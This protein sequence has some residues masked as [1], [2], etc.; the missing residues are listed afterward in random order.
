[1]S[2]KPKWLYLETFLLRIEKEFKAKGYKRLGEGAFR[3]VCRKPNGKTV[4]KIPTNDSGFSCNYVEDIMYRKHKSM[5]IL[6]KCN[7]FHYKSI[8]IIEMEYVVPWYHLTTSAQLPAWAH[9]VDGTQVG[10][11]SKNKL[12]C[13]D[14]A[15][16]WDL[17]QSRIQKINLT[18]HW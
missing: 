7:L 3:A 16:N 8:P 17:I 4:I 14:Y 11:T 2:K 13:Y 12:V 1:M 9:K 18:S 6:A 10:F 15:N 5:G